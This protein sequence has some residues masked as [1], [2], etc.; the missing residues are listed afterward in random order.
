M[1]FAL[2]LPGQGNYAWGNS[3][4]DMLCE[5]RRRAGLPALSVAWGAVTGVGYVEEILQV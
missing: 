3:V 4:C 2:I 1:L 5:S